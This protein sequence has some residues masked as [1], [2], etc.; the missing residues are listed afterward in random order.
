MYLHKLTEYLYKNEKACE[1]DGISLTIVSGTRTFI[2]KNIWERKYKN[3]K[4]EG[5]NDKEIIQKIMLW[6]LFHQPRDTIGERI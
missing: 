6:S 3:Y 2:Q 4:E 5:L 1:K